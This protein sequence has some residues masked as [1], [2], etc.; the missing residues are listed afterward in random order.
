MIIEL[1]LIINANQTLLGAWEFNEYIWDLRSNQIKD[2][3]QTMINLESKNFVVNEDKNRI[4]YKITDKP[5]KF[6]TIQNSIKD[7]LKTINGVT[8]VS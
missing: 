7:Y 4:I 2:F 3:I 6:Y 5:Y 8:L 1:Q